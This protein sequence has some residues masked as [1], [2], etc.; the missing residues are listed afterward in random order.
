[1]M[2][3]L[4]T[5][6]VFLPLLAALIIG[7]VP[8]GNH[9]QARA[10]A[11]I[12][13]FLSVL[14]AGI[15]YANFDFGAKGMQF[16]Q[17]AEWINIA[18]VYQDKSLVIGYD[19]GVDGLSMPFVLLT[20]IV[21]FLAVLASGKVQHR[22]KEYFIWF[23]LLITG[24]YGCFVALDLFLFFL[25]LELTLIPMYFLI[26]IW[27]GEKKGRV[28]S[29]LLVYRGLGSAFILVAF[30][31]LAFKAAAATGT[32]SLNMLTIADAF[33]TASP[34]IITTAFK[35][36]IFLVLLL[37]I[38]IEEAFFPFH[39]WL[40]DTH[41][42]APSAVSMIVGGVVMKIGAYVLFRIAVGILPDS[43]KHYAI[44]I[45]VLGVINIVYAALIAMVQKDW[46]RLLAFSAISHMGIVLLGVAAMNQAGIQGGLFMTISS[47]L[48]SALLFFLIGAIKER[49]G[50]TMIAGLGGLSKPMPVLAG[51]LLAAAL[52]SLGLP[53]MSGFIS[54]ILAFMGSFAAFPV[55][56]VFGALGIIL[57]AVYLLWAMQRTTYG[58]TTAQLEGVSDARAVEY[59]PAVVLLA[60][61]IL[62]GVYP[63]ILADL[64][65]PS[66]QTFVSRI[67]G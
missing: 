27:G 35:N 20:G 32:I 42:Q 6:I 36:G 50:T 30:I 48:L 3:N 67:G 44:L 4:L 61:I 38:L 7:F 62:I 16:T 25:F 15:V 19:L 64:V 45:A 52:G 63:Q 13:T 10:I 5:L 41:E 40:P 43:I 53:G 9:S 17:S 59:V 34:D 14:L 55:L 65:N 24:L 2:G 12:A 66:I 26:G 46:R 18:N 58:P 23:L 56:S 11:L 37:A 54:E 33:A 31:G 57:A 28:A 51:F 47:G 8:R 22:T 49:T 1:M 29:K 21:S 39:T 60:L